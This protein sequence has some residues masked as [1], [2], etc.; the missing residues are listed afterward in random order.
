MVIKGL[1][2]AIVGLGVVDGAVERKVDRDPAEDAIS[3]SYC[4]SCKSA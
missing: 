2:E 3:I 1:V 4:A